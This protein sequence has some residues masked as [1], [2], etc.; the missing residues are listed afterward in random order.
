M[1]ADGAAGI[2]TLRAELSQAKERARRSNA[3]AEKAAS[4]LKAEQAAHCQSEDRMA[5]IA[6][7]LQE[8]A[9]RYELLKKENQEKTADIEKALQAAKETRCDSRAAREEL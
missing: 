1:T 3:A 9:S 5:K 8:A 7:E 6:L 2:E 4:E